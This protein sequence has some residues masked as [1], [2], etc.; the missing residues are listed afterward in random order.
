MELRIHVMDREP[1]TIFE[2]SVTDAFLTHAFLLTDQCVDLG[3]YTAVYPRLTFR[4]QTS[5]IVDVPHR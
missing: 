2:I 1:S 3:H 5:T 4:R